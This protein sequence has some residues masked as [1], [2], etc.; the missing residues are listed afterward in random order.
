MWLK[1]I[2]PRYPRAY[3][4]ALLELVDEGAVDRDSLIQDLLGWMSETD[5][6]EFCDRYFRDEDTNEPLIGPPCDQDEEDS[7][8]DPNWVGS[9]HH[10]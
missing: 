10:Y 1:I 3:T 7:I 5:V 6:E 2:D 4:A 8:N 9:R